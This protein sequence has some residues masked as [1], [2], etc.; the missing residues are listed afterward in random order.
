MVHSSY[1]RQNQTSSYDVEEKKPTPSKAYNVCYVGIGWK[2]YP[3]IIKKRLL[4][5]LFETHRNLA[6]YRYYCL[7][8]SNGRCS[9]V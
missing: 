2:C 4:D 5:A 1:P 7:E 6:N 3:D 8:L 9:W